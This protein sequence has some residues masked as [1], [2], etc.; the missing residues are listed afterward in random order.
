MQ[1]APLSG[2]SRCCSAPARNRTW[3]LRIKSPLLCQL[4]YKGACRPIVA[5]ARLLL[6][7]RRRRRAG[8]TRLQRGLRADVVELT[9]QRLAH[10]RLGQ[11]ERLVARQVALA[12]LAG[13]IGELGE[14]RV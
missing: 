3:N 13:L 1:T 10:V 6:G 7:R 2:A 9:L 11:L 5:S 14:R 4:S 12:Q 8:L